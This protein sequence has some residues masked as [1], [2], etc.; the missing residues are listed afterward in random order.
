MNTPLEGHKRILGILYLIGGT[1]SLLGML[2][3]NLFLST[4]FSFALNE[5]NADEKEIIEFI[6]SIVQ[7]VPIIVI[8]LYSIPT[9]IAALGLLT[10]KS[11]SMLFALIV[12]CFKLFSFPIGTAIGIY[13]IWIYSEDQK[14]KKSQVGFT[15]PNN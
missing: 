15:S 7:Y 12:G 1:L 3:L 10:G 14:A 2:F 5:V 11:W 9:L 13:A 6:L 4:I 8:V